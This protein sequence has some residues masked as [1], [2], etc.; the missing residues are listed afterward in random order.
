MY[1][2]LPDIHCLADA[3]AALAAQGVA[4]DTIYQDVF[5]GHYRFGSYPDSYGVHIYFNEGKLNK[6]CFTPA[7]NLL[8]VFDPPRQDAM[9]GEKHYLQHPQR[10]AAPLQ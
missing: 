10:V 1:Q 4:V 9:C 3:S 2:Q 5:R 6:A 7:L 8:Q